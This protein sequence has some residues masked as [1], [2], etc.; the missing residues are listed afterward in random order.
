MSNQPFNSAGR[1][2]EIWEVAKRRASFKSHLLV[3]IVINVFLWAIWY[4]TS[5]DYYNRGIPWPAWTTAGWG[6]GLTFHYLGAY[7]FPRS[8][9]VER[10]YEKLMKSKNQQ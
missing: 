5:G 1:D 9:N 8:N 10:E 2:P 7:V 6:I 3:Y 4:F